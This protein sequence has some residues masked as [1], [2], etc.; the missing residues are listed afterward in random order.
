M[1]F[2][3]SSVTFKDCMLGPFRK[4]QNSCPAPKLLQDYSESP[5]YV[6]LNLFTLR[7]KYI[8][9]E[10][11]KKSPQPTFIPPHAQNLFKEI[12]GRRPEKKY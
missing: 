1:V 3:I 9:K 2:Q 4:I 6:F 5:I 10:K 8:V 12:T 11:K 7:T